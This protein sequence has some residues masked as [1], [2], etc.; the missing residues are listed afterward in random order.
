MEFVRSIVDVFLHLDNQLAAVI[1]AYGT[2]AYGLL[3]LVLFFETG[4]VVTPFLPG[5]SLLFAAGAL[6]AG[7]TLKVGWL[8]VLCAL[9][10]II[11]DTVNYAIGRS[12]GPR[13]F[14]RDHRWVKRKH[15]E[16]AHAFYEKYGGATIFLARFLP[17]IR[18]FAP[19]VAGVARMRY[20]KFFAYNVVGGIVWTGLFLFSGYYFGSIPVVKNNFSIIILAIVVLSILPAVIGAVRH[21]ALTRRGSSDDSAPERINQ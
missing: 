12:I 5:D 13:V 1:Q 16:R 19:F 15:L 21:G 18:T 9:A 7:G 17:I 10:A 14:E 8:F 20:A 2:F 6:A 4:I 3:F 11:G